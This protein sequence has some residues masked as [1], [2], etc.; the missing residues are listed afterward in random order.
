M[1]PMKTSGPGHCPIPAKRAAATIRAARTLAAA[2][3]NVAGVTHVQRRLPEAGREIMAAMKASASR[4]TRKAVPASGG[5]GIDGTAV[6]RLDIA[7][8]QYGVTRARPGCPTL[9]YLGTAEKSAPNHLPGQR[10]FTAERAKV[11][12]ASASDA[13][14][15]TP[16]TAR[17]SAAIV[18]ASLRT[19][20]MTVNNAAGALAVVDGQVVA[21][22]ALTVGRGVIIEVHAVA[23]PDKLEYVKSMVAG[24][25][26]SPS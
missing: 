18:V 11:R 25:L 17:L 26:R 23:N 8:E 7:T 13:T 6:K 24:R 9:C 22:L 21:A 3:S 10:Y 15:N 20:P 19:R 2:S 5:G 16:T 12:T 1:V 4:T 14:A